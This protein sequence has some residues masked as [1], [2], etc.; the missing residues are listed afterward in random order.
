MNSLAWLL[1]TCTDPGVRDGARAVRFAEEAVAATGR[2]DPRILD[3][4][5]A[6]HAEA[7]QFDTGAAVEKEAMALLQTDEERNEYGARLKLYEAGTPY[8]EVH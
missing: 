5:A 8:R 1:A 3:T 6:A 2:R 7:G 4:L